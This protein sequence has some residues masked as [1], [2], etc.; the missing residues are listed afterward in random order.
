M[1]LFLVAPFYRASVTVTPRSRILFARDLPDSRFCDLLLVEGEV[2]RQNLRRLFAAARLAAANDGRLLLVEGFRGNRI[3]RTGR[4]SRYV[5]GSWVFALMQRLLERRGLIAPLPRALRKEISRC[6]SEEASAIADIG[7]AG[8]VGIAGTPC[9]SAARARRYLTARLPQSQVLTP[10]RALGTE[11]LPP[12]L[13][14][15]WQATAPRRG[16]AWLGAVYEAP[17][18]ALHALSSLTGRLLSPP[19][20]EVRLAHRLRVDRR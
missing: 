14:Q 18:W 12:R 17:N 6:T 16:E 20:L 9:P 11:A 19:P 1:G 7:G 2:F 13:E 5:S 8:V 10:E 3:L 15:F 4:G